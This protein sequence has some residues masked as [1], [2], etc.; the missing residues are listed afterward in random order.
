MLKT[1]PELV[2]EV[3]PGLRCISAAEAMAELANNHGTL[4]DVREAIEAGQNPVKGATNIPRGILEMRLP[5]MH[6]DAGTPLYI[7][8]A[9]G[10]RATLAG[11][12]LQRLGYKSVSVITCNLETIIGTV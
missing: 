3:R 5:M 10:A 8:C 9:T 1:I 2:Q 12:Q 11:E 7:H 4:I 6:P